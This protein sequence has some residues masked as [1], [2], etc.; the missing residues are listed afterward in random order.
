LRGTINE[1]NIHQRL[2]LPTALILPGRIGANFQDSKFKIW[3][4]DVCAGGYGYLLLGCGFRLV[5]EGEVG[6]GYFRAITNHQTVIN[7]SAVDLGVTVIKNDFLKK[8][9]WLGPVGTAG[10]GLSWGTYF[11][12]QQY[13]LDLTIL[14]ELDSQ[15]GPFLY[16]N[17]VFPLYDLQ[18]RGLTVHAQ[19]D[20]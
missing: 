5:F 19:L 4:I 7:N 8:P 16:D 10:G 6:L 14:Y 1:I 13:H 20:F 3:S 12:D 2:A 9:H 11:C 15:W 17:L 18:Y